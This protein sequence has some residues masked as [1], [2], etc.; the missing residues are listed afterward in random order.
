[1]IKNMKKLIKTETKMIKSDSETVKAY[2]AAA[3]AYDKTVKMY[4][5]IA[6]IE[7][8][9]NL[10][11]TAK[12]NVFAEAAK[13]AKAYARAARAYIESAMVRVEFD[14]INRAN[15]IVRRDKL[16]DRASK[17][18]ETNIDDY[19]KS[20]DKII[21]TQIVAFEEEAKA[22]KFQSEFMLNF[23]YK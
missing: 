20:Y 10:K 13:V 1:M 19:D 18:C 23:E 22:I 2:A 17:N 3:N 15:S 14:R 8:T 9:E 16:L 21:K 6:A 5:K 4:A 7:D 11:D 12:I